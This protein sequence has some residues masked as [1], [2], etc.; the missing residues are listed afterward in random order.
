MALDF[1]NK[2]NIPTFHFLDAVKNVCRPNQEY[3]RVE[4]I[5]E[6]GGKHVEK[7]LDIMELINFRREAKIRMKAQ[8]DVTEKYLTQKLSARVLSDYTSQSDE[9]NS[10]DDGPSQ[11][12]EKGQVL[13]YSTQTV[14]AREKT[15]GVIKQIL[16]SRTKEV[17]NL[18]QLY[19]H[20]DDKRKLRWGIAQPTVNP[21]LITSARSTN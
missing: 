9:N 17:D 5:L 7:E 15:A 13:P 20:E 16:A 2:V 10:S 11:A 21:D 6:K 14:T 1:E 18:I 12:L 4:R 3:K 19:T 8:M